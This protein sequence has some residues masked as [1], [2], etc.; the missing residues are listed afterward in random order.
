MKK[1]SCS[2]MRKRLVEYFYG[3]ISGQEKEMVR[4]HLEVC[5]SCRETWEGMKGILKAPDGYAE[6][7]M[8]EGFWESYPKRVLDRISE[9]QV[10]RQAFRR[11]NPRK[12]LVFSTAGLL[13][14]LMV[15]GSRFYL[16]ERE[17]A[18][19]PELYHNL[20]VIQNLDLI[21]QVIGNQVFDP[22]VIQEYSETAA[23]YSKRV[24]HHRFHQFRRLE[25][26]EK[27]AVFD[28]YQEWANY[29]V[30]DKEASR[31]VY[32]L[33]KAV[34]HPDLKQLP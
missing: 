3:E 28:N 9:E 32:N 12:L 17:I 7:E 14:L 24:I 22:E 15:A 16:T 30:S 13:F 8:T 29:S 34:S 21:N 23:P 4:E 19:N 31:N 6:P 25:E 11:Y 27:N 33:L 2:R 10:S 5:N 20:E 26:S 18:R 1:N